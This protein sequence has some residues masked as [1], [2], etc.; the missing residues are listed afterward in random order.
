MRGLD[1]RRFLAICL[2]SAAAPRLAAQAS[3]SG[4]AFLAQF[5]FESRFWP[6]LHHF[7]YILGRARNGASD[8]GRAAV[9][10]APL[11]TAGFDA[12]PESQRRAWEDAL[13]LYQTNASK[14]DIG[15]G[16][17][18]DVNY[19]V[20]DLAGGES[21]EGVQSVEGVKEIPPKPW[22]MPI[23][24]EPTPQPTLP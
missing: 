20:A 16:P 11:D 9:R 14:L 13:A 10:E 23:R 2:S 18:V 12:L 24:A 3:P 17:L 8:S 4:A 19:A 6:N 21:L 1:R 7:L 22:P 15:Y 5:H